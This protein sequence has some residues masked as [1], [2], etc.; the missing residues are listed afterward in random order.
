MS[1][2]E[3]ANV[4]PPKGELSLWG[5]TR[6]WINCI[7]N[8]GFIQVEVIEEVFIRTENQGFASYAEQSKHC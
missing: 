1:G 6:S 5:F 8:Q 7:Q 3:T 4:M 2:T